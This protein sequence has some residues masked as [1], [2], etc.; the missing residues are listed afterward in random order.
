MKSNVLTSQL[1]VA[2][3]DD[4]TLLTEALVPNPLWTQLPITARIDLNKVPQDARA[5]V[6]IAAHGVAGN[7]SNPLNCAIIESAQTTKTTERCLL[8]PTSPAADKPL[9]L[10]S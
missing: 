8:S 7:L 5:Q 1:E 3:V 4:V 10:P 6:D 2:A 9:G